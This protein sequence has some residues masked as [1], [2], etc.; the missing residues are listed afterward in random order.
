MYYVLMLF[1]FSILNHEIY[2]IVEKYLLSFI[3]YRGMGNL[4]K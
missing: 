1:L 2:N 3:R 4:V